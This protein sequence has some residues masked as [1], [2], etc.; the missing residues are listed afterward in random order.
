[1]T[2]CDK[3]TALARLLVSRGKLFT[4][5]CVPIVWSARYSKTSQR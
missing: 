5:Q 1:M 4:L 3:E 2:L